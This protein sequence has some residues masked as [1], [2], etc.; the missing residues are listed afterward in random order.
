[1]QGVT[2]YSLQNHA[3]NPLRDLPTKTTTTGNINNINNVINE[4]N[5]ENIDSISMNF[6]NSAISNNSEWILFSPF[7]EDDNNGSSNNSGDS[8]LSTRLSSALPS[9]TK[10]KRSHSFQASSYV[11]SDFDENLKSNDSIE[12]N[13]DDYEEFNWN[14]D[15]EED[16]DDDD[17]DDDSL[18]DDVRSEIQN[19]QQ[20]RR[21]E[22]EIKKHTELVNKI[23][24]WKSNV[25]SLS[26]H[27]DNQETNISK[28]TKLDDP[29][30]KTKDKQKLN[31]KNKD[32]R[33]KEIKA[34]KKVVGQLRSSLKKEGIV[35]HEGIFMNNPDLESSVP[36]YW[37]RLMLDNLIQHTS[38]QSIS[39]ISVD[40]KNKNN[41]NFWEP[42][43]N[44]SVQSLSTGWEGNSILGF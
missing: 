7:N 8:I 9:P 40:I 37:K 12:G 23:D 39:N 15:E 19:M 5:N 29:I 34:F 3:Q 20:S 21:N 14:D 41:R 28:Y 13:E 30:S 17:D 43:E 27:S 35:E 16:N 1:M 44:G 22:I 2:P 26:V 38:E 33:K 4:N 42:E 18:T 24:N 25:K 32:L 6:G 11:I 36:G 10:L 31:K